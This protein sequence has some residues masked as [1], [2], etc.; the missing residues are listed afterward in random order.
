MEDYEIQEK[1]I[2]LRV[3][4]KRQH[5]TLRVLED[6]VEKLRNQLKPIERRYDRIVKPIADK[7]QVLKAAIADLESLARRQARGASTPLDD[8][9]RDRWSASSQSSTRFNI[10]DIKLPNQRPKASEDIKKVYRRLA[11]QH[12]PDLAQNEQDRLQ[13]TRLM[14]QINDAYAKRDLE[15]LQALDNSPPDEDEANMPLTML[16]LRRLQAECA[17]L[18]ERIEALKIEKFDLTHGVLMDLKIQEKWDRRKG[19]NLL[20]EMA[21]TFETQY[22]ELLRRYDDL[23]RRVN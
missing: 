22:T 16:K 9:W 20:R 1:I 15:A 7:V 11:R 21:A 4:I 19:Q 6:E 3:T 10:E 13:R 8:I 5:E 12:H 14:A 23:R 18:T 17:E 2:R